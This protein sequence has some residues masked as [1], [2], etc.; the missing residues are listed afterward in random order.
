MDMAGRRTMHF[1]TNPKTRQYQVFGAQK[2]VWLWLARGFYDASIEGPPVWPNH[3]AVLRF[4]ELYDAIE[5]AKWW[6]L[7]VEPSNR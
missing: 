2:A 6:Q 7:P 1:M 5:F 3:Y 4:L